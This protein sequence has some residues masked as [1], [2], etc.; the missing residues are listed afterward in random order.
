MLRN[1]GI[2]ICFVGIPYLCS[3]VPLFHTRNRWMVHMTAQQSIQP[4]ESKKEKSK[5]RI[6][7]HARLYDLKGTTSAQQKDKFRR[8]GG[9]G[10]LWAQYDIFLCKHCLARTSRRSH[11]VSV[12]AA[13]MRP[14][15]TISP[16]RRTRRCSLSSFC[17]VYW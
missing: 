2:G 11:Q 7:V 14:P 5:V 6:C 8:E 12:R 15:H 4:G 10:L 16:L 13:H 9:C 17:Y 3:V 1:I